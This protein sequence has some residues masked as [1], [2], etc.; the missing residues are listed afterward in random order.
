MKYYFTEQLNSELLELFL[1]ESFEYCDKFSLIWRDDILDDHYV[2][3]KDELLEQL[4]TFMV[5]QAKVQEWPGTK[6]LNSEATMYTFRLTQQSIF[7][8]LKFLKTL[9]QCHCFEDLVLYHKS[10]LPFLTT[11]FHEE[12]AFLDVDETTVKQIF[13]QI[14]ILQELLIAQDK[15]KQ[16]YAVSVKCDDSIVYLPPVKIIKIFD[17]EIQAEMFIE[18]MSSSG[19][20]EEDFVILPFFDDSC[21]ADN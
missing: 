17:S 18:R 20:S 7:A 14:P 3:E 13:K 8:L 15:C 2:S 12:I 5:G 9:F 4:S 21:D 10:G 19:Y 1:I 16:R 6:I 11:I